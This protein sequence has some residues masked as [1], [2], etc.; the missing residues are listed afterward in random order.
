VRS[1]APVALKH[2]LSPEAIGEIIAAYDGHE[3]KQIEAFM[4]QEKAEAAAARQKV[5]QEFGSDLPTFVQ[6]AAKGAKFLFGDELMGRLFNDPRY[7]N[8]TGFIK[9]MAQFGR[10]I[11]TDGGIGGAPQGAEEDLATRW[12]KSSAPRKE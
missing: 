6:D 11:K 1:I 2:K 5:Q 3:R 12:L 9:A 7:G 8:D 4:A 10:M